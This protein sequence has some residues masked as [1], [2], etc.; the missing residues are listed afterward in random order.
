MAQG[1]LLSKKRKEAFELES[2]G[3][4]SVRPKVLSLTQLLSKKYS[5]LPDLPEKI[6]NSFGKMTK[7]F[8]M[9]LYGESGNG[10]TNML[11]DLLKALMPHGVILYISLE[12]GTEATMQLTAIQHLSEDHKGRIKFADETMTYNNL[13]KWLK[14]RNSEQFIVIDSVQYWDIDLKRYKALKSRFKKKTFIF[15]SHIEGKHPDGFVAKKIKY[16]ATYKVLVENF[17]AFI[18][19]RLGGNKP[20][21]IWEEGAKEKWGEKEF[22]KIFKIKPE[23]KKK[24]TNKNETSKKTKEAKNETSIKNE[25]STDNDSGNDGG[26]PTTVQSGGSTSSDRLPTDQSSIRSIAVDQE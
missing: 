17:V 20:Y 15:I 7:N 6:T 3:D 8:I 12:E 24:E 10:K 18:R 9:L 11:I 26:D 16:D 14:K 21:L 19:S 25:K 1:N 22:N 4:D 23:R 13:M 2:D 5:F